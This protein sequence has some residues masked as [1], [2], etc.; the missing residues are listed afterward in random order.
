VEGDEHV[1]ASEDRP[2]TG[3]MIAYGYQAKGILL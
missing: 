1:G 3:Q 2:L